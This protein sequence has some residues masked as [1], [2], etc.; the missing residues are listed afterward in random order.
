MPDGGNS[1]MDGAS[2]INGSVKVNDEIIEAPSVYIRDHEGNVMVPLRAVVEALGMS[3]EWRVDSWSILIGGNLVLWPDEV[4]YRVIDTNTSGEFGPAPEI[5][6]GRTFVSLPFFN[7][8]LPDC[9][10]KIEDGF[11]VVDAL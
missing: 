4:R 5:R 7:F 9:Q 2:S 1:I 11:V 3:V 6:E 8:L 10:A